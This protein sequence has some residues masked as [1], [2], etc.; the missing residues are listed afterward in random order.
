MY[1]ANST[2][3]TASAQT[4]AT[5]TTMSVA[6]VGGFTGSY[7]GNGEII[8]AKKIT[9]TGFSTEYMLVQSASRNEPSSEKDFSGKLFVVRGY[10]GSS[11][12]DS[13]SVG[14]AASIAT[15]YEDGQVIVSTGRIGTG[16]IRLHA[17]PSDPYTP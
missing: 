11:E 17:N 6:N 14:D 13:G 15:T 3:I 9:D 16:F 7:E 2:M 12:T 1:V 10:S 8:S 4:S 5:A